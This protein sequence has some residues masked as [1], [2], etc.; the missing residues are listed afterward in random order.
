MAGAAIARDMDIREFVV[1][2]RQLAAILANPKA[3]ETPLNRIKINAVVEVKRRFDNSLDPDDRPWAPLLF[4]RPRGAGK[5]LRDTGRLMAS[6]QATVQGPEF[7][8]GTNLEYAALHQYGGTVTPKKAKMLTIPLTRE[9]VTAGSARAMSGLFI[10]R[11][12]SGNLF[13][14]ER[15]EKR[16]KA[17]GLTLH[18]LLKD[19][20][21]ITARPFLGFGE[22]LLSKV[23]AIFL[24]WLEELAGGGRGG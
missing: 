2:Q 12:K 18:W 24:D 9:A 23:D 14:A 7:T 11:S 4:A 22:R 21:T 15:K 10:F 19:S 8:Q 13:L 17:A 6:I 20:V 16:G 1:D 3:L 5:P